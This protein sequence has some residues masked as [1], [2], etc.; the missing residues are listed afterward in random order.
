MSRKLCTLL[1]YWLIISTITECSHRQ[2][3]PSVLFNSLIPAYLLEVNENCSGWPWGEYPLLNFDLSHSDYLQ[4]TNCRQ[5]DRERDTARHDTDCR[6][7]LV[8][9]HS[10]PSSTISPHPSADTPASHFILFLPTST[11]LWPRLVLATEYKSI[12]YGGQKDHRD[13]SW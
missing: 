8:T 1:I 6:L 7:S 13:R 9:H 3:Y 12:H 11:C 2:V 10:W 5:R 4:A